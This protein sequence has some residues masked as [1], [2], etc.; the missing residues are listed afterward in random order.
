M[1]FERKQTP[2]YLRFPLYAFDNINYKLHNVPILKEQFKDKFCIYPVYNLT[3]D[4]IRLIKLISEI[5]P[6]H[7][8]DNNG[9]R[10]FIKETDKILPHDVPWWHPHISRIVGKCF[11]MM[12]FKFSL[13]VEK[14]PTM[15]G[16]I[17]EKLIDAIRCGVVP[18]YY[19]N[20]SI[21]TDFHTSGFINVS[22]IRDNYD[23]LEEI[24]RVDSD[25]NEY[26]RR[27]TLLESCR[28]ISDEEFELGFVKFIQSIR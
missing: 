15:D 11:A 2:W 10:T 17:T 27:R 21:S 3:D 23:F 14:T 8:S 20:D 19:G 26:E 12:N 18:I 4:K 6:V 28:K 16:Y 9:T 24:R 13:C 25:K 22:S 7:V 1:G 5:S